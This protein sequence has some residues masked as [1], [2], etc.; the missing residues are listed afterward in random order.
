MAILKDTI[1][2]RQ[3]VLCFQVHQPRRF[4]RI[5]NPTTDSLFDDT[6]D[7][8]II[9]RL[10]QN[11]YLPTNA[12]L[13]KLIEQFPELRINFAISGTAL[14]HIERYSPEALQSFK[15]L[16]ATGA[17]D[18]LSETYYHSLAFMLESEEMEIQI[19]EHSEKIIEHFEL[20]PSVFMNTNLIYNDEI[21]RRLNMMGL[22]G[23]ITEGAGRQLNRLSPHYLYEHRDE[24]GFKILMRNHSLSDDIAFR[25]PLSNWNLTAE[26][27]MSWLH[28]MPENEKLVTLSLD[29]GT[30][31]E[32]HKAESGICHFLE[33]LLLLLSIEN[34]YTLSTAAE[35][36]QQYEASMPI[37]IP[38][39]VS[40][41]GCELSD[42]VGNDKQREAFAAIIELENS[43]KAKNDSSLLKIWRYL[44]T[45]DN[46]YYLSEKAYE[47]N[48][49]SPYDSLDQAFECYMNVVQY[50]KDQL[51]DGRTSDEKLNG[52][53]EAE[54]RKVEA[55][56]EWALNIDSRE[57]FHNQSSTIKNL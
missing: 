39:Y 56:P 10:A 26:T 38:D 47:G 1:D 7:E 17:V 18:F 5:V 45:V 11:C 19:L 46:F 25:A 57:G 35:I 49:F 44:Q 31:G 29:Y 12:L 13:L 48:R 22:H 32:H 36:V 53:V 41:H 51:A 15:D 54:R 8:E 9:Q 33:H 43:V 6:L 52:A 34:S 30:F 42:W 28:A 14:E 2:K 21:G 27:F 20:H 23:V 16:A 55:T 4:K 37:L 50:L 3:L 40:I 24:N